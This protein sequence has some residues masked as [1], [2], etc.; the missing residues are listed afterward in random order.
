MKIKVG[1]SNRHIH[2]KKEHLDILF[3]EN[4]ELKV[5][6]PLTQP[7]EFASTD[8]VTIKTEKSEINKVRILGPIREYTQVEI[9][10]TDAYKLGLKPPVRDS[11]DIK[12][13]APITLIGP[14]GT[15]NLKE[16]CILATRHIHMSE[17]DAKKY[18]F[19][20][21]DEVSVL[22]KGEKGGRLDHVFIKTSKE[23]YLELHLDTDDGNSHMVTK[24]TEGEIVMD[25]SISNL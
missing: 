15:L 17:E 7:D 6:R 9:S 11:G 21:H 19:H 14:K 3:G 20:N 24:D 4:Y 8:Y 23:A 25:E 2:L 10:L 13:S 1:I 12:G 22:I 18:G 5:D 16:G